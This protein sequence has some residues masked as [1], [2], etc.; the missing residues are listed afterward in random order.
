LDLHAPHEVG[1]DESAFVSFDIT[2]KIMAQTGIDEAMIERLVRGFYAKVQSDP[3]LGP[4][5]AAQVGD[6]NA[7][8]TKLCSFWS[9]V[10]LMSRRYH[11]QPMQAHLNLPVDR[12]HFDR[13][14]ALFEETATNL[15][16]PDATAH[17]VERARCIADSIERW[18]GKAHRAAGMDEGFLKLRWLTPS[19]HRHLD[20]C[21]FPCRP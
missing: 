15:C 13:W 16:P 9:S 11:G 7:H 2:H 6:W 14:I 3:V 5:F 12:S 21:G 18:G 8:I 4:I 19:S 20:V 1:N 10:A 17:F